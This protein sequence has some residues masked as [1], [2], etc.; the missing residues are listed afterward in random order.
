[1]ATAS[2]GASITCAAIAPVRLLKGC[3]SRKLF[4]CGYH[5]WTYALDGALLSATEID[6][7]EGFRPED[8]ALVPLRV[9]ELFNFIFVNLDPGAQPV[10]GRLGELTQQI[11]RVPSQ[12]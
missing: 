8:F 12:A 4:R 9:E 7:V 1:V 3:G 5:G 6:G 2:C 10:R 11:E